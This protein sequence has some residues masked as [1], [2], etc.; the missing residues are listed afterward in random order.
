[1]RNMTA[2]S[3][4]LRRTVVAMSWLNRSSRI[5]TPTL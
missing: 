4:A 2:M 5:C 1:M 3:A